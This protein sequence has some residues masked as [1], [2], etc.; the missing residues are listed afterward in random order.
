MH[1]PR[2]GVEMHTKLGLPSRAGC[3][4]EADETAST[5]A[6]MMAATLT[7]KNTKIRLIVTS[8]GLS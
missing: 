6:E 7:A 1:T 4:A 3:K 5:T 2:Y 8:K